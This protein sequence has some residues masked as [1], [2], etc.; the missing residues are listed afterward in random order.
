MGIT[1]VFKRGQK[2]DKF[3]ELLI[4]QSEKTV[5]GLRLLE[6][7]FKKESVQEE[8]Q[9]E[10][11]RRREFEADEI[12]R[13][14]IDEL[15]NTFV[16]PLDREDIFNLSLY[17]DDM[18]DYAYSSVEEMQ[19]LG[20]DPDEH[21][22]TMVVTIREAAEELALAIRRLN[23]NPRVSG[24]HARRAKKLENEVERT[25]RLAIGDLFRKARDFEPLMEMLRRREVYRHISNMADRVNMAADVVGMIVMKIV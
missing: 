4:Q 1:G 21:L 10:K 18:L 8:N 25:Y 23:N 2:R 11:M 15:Y 19:I 13:I 17:I 20:I 5:E 12:R 6:K 9:L 24:E 7:W 14:L 16:T 3:V 22:I